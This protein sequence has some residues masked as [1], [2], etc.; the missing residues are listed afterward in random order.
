MYKLQQ[1]ILSVIFYVVFATFA[2]FCFCNLSSAQEYNSS[3]YKISN[4]VM[5]SGGGYSSSAN[6]ELDSSIGQIGIGPSSATNF[7]LNA[8]F[9]YWPYVSTPIVS[10]TAGNGQV[11]LSWTP[12]SGVLGWPVNPRYNIGYST[13]SGGPYTFGASLGTT[14][15]SGVQGSLSNGTPYYF[16]IRVEDVFGNIIATSSEAAATPSA[17]PPSG[18]GGGGGGGGGFTAQTIVIFSGKAYPKSIVTLLKDAQIT[19]TT[20]AGADASF[21]ITLSSLTVGNYIFSLYSED[22]NGIRSSLLTFPVSVTAGATTN[23]S[24]IFLAPTISV[25]KS[26]VKRGDDIAIF[27]QSVPESDIVISVHSDEEYFSKTISDKD[28]I[29]LY[30]FDTSFLDIGSHLTKSKAS[31]G[32]LLVSGYSNSVN[33]KVGTQN[34]AA[35][36]SQKCPAR[37][38]LNGDCRVNLID[39][40]IASY[41]YKQPLSDS[42]KKLEI[43]EL[44][45][46][47]KVNLVDFSIMAYY[48]TG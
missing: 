12:A 16:V 18:G 38:D 31:I 46:D 23:V 40:S 4:P 47:G 22:N 43:S 10:A 21:M 27:G 25:D 41:W 11:S 30:N 1:K 35:T 33:F 34:I 44:N 9:L 6:Y 3:N 14:S 32:N 24:G 37:G 7:G 26:E 17:P 15:L 39:F 28:G 48:W 19:S 36:P 45:G 8:G 42:F 20:V 13:V 5:T 2:F 29:Y